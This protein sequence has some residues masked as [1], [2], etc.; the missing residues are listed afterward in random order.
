ML[1][2]FFFLSYTTDSKLTYIFQLWISF[3]KILIQAWKAWNFIKESET[4]LKRDSNTNVFMWM[5]RNF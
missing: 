5:L 2:H 3:E 4:F 1:K